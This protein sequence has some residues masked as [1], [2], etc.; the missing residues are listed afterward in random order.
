M[1][2]YSLFQ[3]TCLSC[4]F[5]WFSSRA[6]GPTW[7]IWGSWTRC[8]SSTIGGQPRPPTQVS[9]Y[10]QLYSIVVLVELNSWI[11]SIPCS[12]IEAFQ[13]LCP[14]HS[15]VSFN[16]DHG[17]PFMQFEATAPRP[18]K[19]QLDCW[20][21][22]VSKLTLLSRI[23]QCVISRVLPHVEVDFRLYVIS[24]FPLPNF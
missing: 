1:M 20:E 4:S 14:Q 16:L 7:R 22:S 24:S 13:P 11:V 10:R 9:K 15:Y 2:I 18:D 12:W 5:W 8:S 23:K 17:N 3:R 19:C 21:T 6:W